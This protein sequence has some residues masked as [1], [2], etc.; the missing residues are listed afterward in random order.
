MP[1]TK[2]FP[3]KEPAV[4]VE[5]EDTK[6]SKTKTTKSAVH[7]PV[8]ATTPAVEPKK[9]AK[10][11]AKKD[12]MSV[13]D[14]VATTAESSDD[15][16][17]QNTVVTDLVETSITE[18]FTE[19]ITRFQTL[20]GQFQSLKTELKNLEKKTVKQLKVVQK[21]QNKK[22]KKATRA[23]SGFVKPAPISNELAHF[24][25]RPE[26]S[27]MARTD[28]TREINKYIRANNLQDKDN[29]RKI[30]PDKLLSDLLKINDEVC[31]TYFNLQRY[32]GPHFPKQLKTDTSTTTVSA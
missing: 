7:E 19:F 24:L 28:V 1:S 4:A 6:K 3:K 31:L 30:N 20:I 2:S 8:V 29:G 16:A 27:E 17:I 32:M 14:V 23:P 22:N 25:G 18:N 12:T 11:R 9:V 26:G 15:T 5:S 21:I 10:S 13:V